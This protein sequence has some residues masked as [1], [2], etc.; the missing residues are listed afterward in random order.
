M[1]R[2]LSVPMLRKAFRLSIR[3]IMAAR[4]MGQPLDL[5]PVQEAAE[6]IVRRE[7]GFAYYGQADFGLEGLLTAKGRNEHAGGDWSNLDRALAPALY[8]GLF[9]LYA[10]TD[11]IQLE[12]LKRLCE[13]G[14][15]KAPIEG[16]VVL[17]PMAARLVV[18]QDLRAGYVGQDGVHY[19]LYLS[20]S[21]VPL[22]DA[23]EAICTIRTQGEPKLRKR[24]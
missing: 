19:D 13:R 3:R 24:S 14:V 2:A 17:D 7:E 15:Y 20:E 23:P 4:E 9:R 22:V 6:A 12:H 1:S 8:N 16:G 21:I 10:G 18:G 11:L 5:S